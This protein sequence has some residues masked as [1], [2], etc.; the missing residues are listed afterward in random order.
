MTRPLLPSLLL[1]AAAL[2][3]CGRSDETSGDATAGVSIPSEAPA[4]AMDGAADRGFMLQKQA[5]RATTEEAAAPPPPPNAPA[6]AGAINA[7]GAAIGQLAG[8]E[9]LGAPMLIRTGQATVRVDSLAIGIARVR[10]LAQRVGALVANTSMNA[11]RDQYPTASLELRVPAARF[12]DLVQ[13][14]AP[15]G[16]VESVNV[17]V[18]DVGEEFT[19]VAAR[20]ANARRL[21]QRLLEVLAGRTGRLADVLAVERELARVREEIERYEGRLRYLRA[22]VAHSALTVTVHEPLPLVAGQPGRGPIGEAF[23]AA[24]RN[25]VQV[26]AAMIAS[27]GALVPVAAIG[28]GAWVLVRRWKGRVGGLTG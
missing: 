18:Q 22:H 25:F 13:G 5:A 3:G 12:D 9:A 14:L 23:R 16:K 28:V 26:I 2:G 20:V 1:L 27:L 19:D 21:E 10:E 11:G 8:Q 7:A 17:Q 15:L 4:P 24:W 6:P